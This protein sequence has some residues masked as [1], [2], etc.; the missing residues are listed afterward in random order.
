[1]CREVDLHHQHR[2][3]AAFLSPGLM[4]GSFNKAPTCLVMHAVIEI[5]K[6]LHQG[7]RLYPIT[8]I[9]FSFLDIHLLQCAVV[10]INSLLWKE[11]HVKRGGSAMGRVIHH[12]ERLDFL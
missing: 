9:L 3:D 4:E 11:L 5:S 10:W 12:S 6:T 7:P 1:M 8:S 2:Y